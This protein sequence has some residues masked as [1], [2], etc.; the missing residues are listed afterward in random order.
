M[1][2][3]KPSLNKDS[4]QNQKRSFRYVH[5]FDLMNQIEKELAL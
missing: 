1:S 3:R 5:K 4:K 2:T